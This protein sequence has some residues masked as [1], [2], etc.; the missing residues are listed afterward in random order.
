MTFITLT[1]KNF[2]LSI[3]YASH[4]FSYQRKRSMHSYS[5]HQ[6]QNFQWWIMHILDVKFEKLKMEK[7][8]QNFFV[9]VSHP[10]KYVKIS[11]ILYHFQTNKKYFFGKC[12][13]QLN[14]PIIQTCK[15]KVETLR[16]CCIWITWPKLLKNFFFLLI[17]KRKK[18][19][20]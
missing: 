2:V 7:S 20:L 4:T 18:I 10:L 9:K 5:L 19:L 12:M 6:F 8:I 17:A 15:K 13:M 16:A 3:S 11:F 14:F 1:L